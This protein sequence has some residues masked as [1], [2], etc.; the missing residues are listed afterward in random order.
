MEYTEQDLDEAFSRAKLGIFTKNP[1]NGAF[2]GSIMGNTK[3]EWYK[4]DND[5]ARTNGKVIQCNPDW[6]MSL[7]GELRI[8]AILHELWHIARL[9]PIRHNGRNPKYW[10]I[11]CDIVINNYLHD[12]CGVDVDTMQGYRNT[13]YI[14][15]SEE[16]IYKAINQDD[17][18]DKDQQIPSSSDLMDSECTTEDTSEI[19]QKVITADQAAKNNNEDGLGKL[20]GDGSSN[21]LANILNNF[22]KPKINWKS[23]LRNY[24]K[25][26]GTKGKTTWNKPSRRYPSMYLPSKT[27]I[28]NKLDH[29]IYFLDVSGSI[30]DSQIKRFNSEVRYIKE[31]FNP[32]LLTLVQFDTE[33]VREDVFTD[34]DRFENINVIAGGGT[35][36]IP[37]HDYIEEKKPTC[38]IIFTDLYCE[39]M[40][41]VDTPVIWVAVDTDKT[42]VPFGKL[43]SITSED[44]ND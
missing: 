39:P 20:A 17:D 38:S 1:N 34:K 27:K 31:V 2:L 42:E 14:G 10:N 6:F 21:E 32:K 40:E 7:N 44:L 16:E 25:E 37:V 35:S 30:S 12:E 11:A 29:L 15:Y 4:E 18:E 28:P 33:I 23:I 26:I 19:L 43:I 3:W 5:T 8:G 22:L 9:H 41:P 24:L 13:N 36:Y